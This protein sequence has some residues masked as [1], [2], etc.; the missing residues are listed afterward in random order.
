[1]LLTHVHLDHVGG[2]PGLIA[3]R[4]LYGLAQPVVIIGSGET[5]A[6]VDRYL[7][8][9]VGPSREAGYRLWAVPPGPVLSQK[10]WRIDAF[11]VSHRG[12]ASLGYRF[13]EESRRPLSAERLAVLG[14]PEG[15][16]RRKL[17]RGFAVT[18]EDGRHISPEMVRGPATVGASLV[19]I[20]DAGEVASLVEPARGADALVIEATFL[21]RDAALAGARGH[22]T[23]ALAAA[24]ARDAGIG[25]LLLTHISGRYRPQEIADEAARIFPRTRVVADFDRIAVGARR[26]KSTPSGR[27]GSTAPGFAAT[28]PRPL[29]GEPA[30]C[31]PHQNP[32]R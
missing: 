4:A 12:T 15:S 1:V 21:D 31:R 24:L 5:I 17:A 22:L 29:P 30:I 10:G 11:A 23:A 3:T 13:S 16:A 8:A 6:F 19:V 18:L 2:L 25:E 28:M 26:R 20:G 9:T 32:R 27:P 14:A 7:A